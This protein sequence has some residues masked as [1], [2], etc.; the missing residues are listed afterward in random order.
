MKASVL[1]IKKPV[2]LIYDANQ[3]INFYMIEHW[4]LM[5]HLSQWRFNDLNIFSY[6]TEVNKFQ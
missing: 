6:L 4:L 1:I 5:G 2:K 3:L